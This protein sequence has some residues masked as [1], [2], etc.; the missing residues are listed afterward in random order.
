MLRNTSQARYVDIGPVMVHAQRVT[1]VGELGW[2]LFIPS[3][4]ASGVLDTLRHT[5]EDVLGDTA[6][7]PLGAHPFVL[8]HRVVVAVVVAVAPCC[9]QSLL[10]SLRRRH[11]GR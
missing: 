9:R 6:G 7:A 3:E 5:C 2:E 11:S 8:C 4:A 10:V 1:Y